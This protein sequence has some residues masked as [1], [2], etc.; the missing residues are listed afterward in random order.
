MTDHQRLAIARLWAAYWKAEAGRLQVK[1]TGTNV[2][3]EPIQIYDLR[4]LLDMVSLPVILVEH[5]PEGP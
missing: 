2:W 4:T 5:R 3:P 1:A